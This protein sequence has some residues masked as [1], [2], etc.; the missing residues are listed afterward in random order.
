M[1]RFTRA[2]ARSST[3]CA[4]YFSGVPAQHG[5]SL[6]LAEILPDLLLAPK[7]GFLFTEEPRP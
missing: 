3:P 1:N 2:G 4:F 7:P 5:E 6:Y